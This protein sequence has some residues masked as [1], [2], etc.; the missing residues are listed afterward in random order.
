MERANQ[1]LA[2]QTLNVHLLPRVAVVHAKIPLVPQTPNAH[3]LQCAAMVHAKI[4]VV[5]QTHNVHILPR[6]ATEHAK[7]LCHAH[8]THNALHHWYA[9]QVLVSLSVAQIFPAHNH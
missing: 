8:Q 6:A 3:L 1:E 5:H 2:Q 9:R 7:T 4:L